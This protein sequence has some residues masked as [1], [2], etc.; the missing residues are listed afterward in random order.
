MDPIRKIPKKVT[1]KFVNK[2][3]LGLRALGLIKV[4]YDTSIYSANVFKVL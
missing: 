2:V 1:N 3:I 4:F